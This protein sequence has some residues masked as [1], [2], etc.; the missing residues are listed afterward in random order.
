MRLIYLFALFIFTVPIMASKQG[1]QQYWKYNYEASVAMTG[2][3]DIDYSQ[4]SEIV[5]CKGTEVE[6]YRHDGTSYALKATITESCSSVALAVGPHLDDTSGET[7]IMIGDSANN[8]VYFYKKTAVDTFAKD[9]E[10][11]DETETKLGTQVALPTGGKF[12]AAVGEKFLVVYVFVDE[13]W[14]QAHRKSI[15]A[16]EVTM[17]IDI[18]HDDYLVIGVVNKYVEWFRLTFSTMKSVKKIT[19]SGSDNIG[20]NVATTVSCRGNQV[21]YLFN[22]AIVLWLQDLDTGT[23]ERTQT[24]QVGATDIEMSLCM[25][26]ATLPSG[27][28]LYMLEQLPSG[29]FGKNYVPT[30]LLFKNEESNFGKKIAFKLDDLAV[31]SDERINFFRNVDSTSC[32]QN[33]YMDISENRCIKCP[34]GEYNPHGN[35]NTICTPLTCGINEH[36]FEGKC[37]ACASGTTNLDGGDVTS[38]DSQ[39]DVEICAVDQYVNNQY[40]CANCPTGM[41]TSGNR[42]TSDVP[43]D[44]VCVAKICLKDQHVDNYECKT[45]ASG[46]T[47]A[48]GDDATQGDTQCLSGECDVDNYVK[49]N[50]CFL[51]PAGSTYPT[52][53]PMTSADTDCVVVTCGVDEKIEDHACVS[54]NDANAERA[55]GDLSTSGDTYCTCK[56]DFRADTAGNCVACGVGEEIIAGSLAKPGAGTVCFPVICPSSSYVESNVCHDCKANSF[57]VGTIEANGADTF[58]RC[59]AGYRSNGNHNCIECPA[60]YYKGAGDSTKDPTNCLCAEGYR[61]STGAGASCVQC[62]E[63]QVNARGDD[64]QGTVDTHCD[65]IIGY[66]ANGNGLCI[67]CDATTETTLAVTDSKSTTTKC[68]CAENHRV[69]V[70]NGVG[71]CVACFDGATRAAGDDPSLNLNSFCDYEGLVQK[72]QHGS[73]GFHL[74]GKTEILPDITVRVGETVSFVNID[75]NR[76][77]P[78]RIISKNDYDNGIELDDKPDGSREP[79]GPPDQSVT[80]AIC[81][82]LAQAEGQELAVIDFSTSVSGCRYKTG[83][84]PKDYA[85]NEYP[86]ADNTNECDSSN[87][88]VRYV[89][90]DFQDI[91]STQFTYDAL[92]PVGGLDESVLVLKPTEVGTFYYGSSASTNNNNY[93]TITVKMPACPDLSTH[94]TQTIDSS[95]T[96]KSGVELTGDLTIQASASGARR[97]RLRGGNKIQLSADHAHR[98]FTVKNGYTLTI[99]NLE[100]M[101]SVTDTGGAILVDGGNAVIKNSIMS[102]NKATAGSGGA[103]RVEN[104]GLV[105]ISDTEFKNNV[106]EGTVK[107]NSESSMESCTGSGGAIF[108]AKEATGKHIGLTV[109]TSTFEDN[110]AKG[111]GGG[112]IGLGGRGT[113]FTS[114]GNIFKKNKADNEG[115]EFGNG[116]AIF[117]GGSNTLYID[118]T[119]F[120][121]NTGQAGAGIGG[122]RPKNVE[123]KDS[124][125]YGN[126]AK[127]GGAYAQR[128]DSTDPPDAGNLVFTGNN[129]TGNSAT[130]EGDFIYRYDS[131]GSTVRGDFKAHMTNNA[132]SGGTRIYMRKTD[133]EVH[134]IDQPHFADGFNSSTGMAGMIQTTCQ[135]AACSYNPLASSCSADPDGFGV[136]CGCDMGVNTISSESS[137]SKT[138]MKTVISVLFASEDM[139]TDIIRMADDNNRYIPPKQGATMSTAKAAAESNVVLSAPLNQEGEAIGEKTV[140]LKPET[141][142]LC[143]SFQSF[144]CEKVTACNSA[145]GEISVEC[146]G[147][148]YFPST[149]TNVTRRRL[150]ESEPRHHLST[151]FAT[152]CIDS[153]PPSLT[154]QCTGMDGTQV[155]TYDICKPN[156]HYNANS[157][158]SCDTGYTSTNNGTVCVSLVQSCKQNYFVF[159]GLCQPCAEGTFNLAGDNPSAGVNTECD[160]NFCPQNFRVLNGECLPC[161]VGEHTPGGDDLSI[162]ETTCCASDEYEKQPPTKDAGGGADR[163]CKKCFG[164]NPDTD[165][166]DKYFSTL[167]CCGKGEDAT[168]RRVYDGFNKACANHA[169]S[170]C[171]TFEKYGTLGTGA[172]CTHNNQCDNGN[173]DI[174]NTD[175]CL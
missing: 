156:S 174:G 3:T 103:I 64:P 28:G 146:D 104:E 126:V 117:M 45:C 155:I 152:N 31:L 89:Q 91:T 8:K 175:K 164:N 94:G 52:K 72:F 92:P 167:K 14:K 50:E 73:G 51:C 18:N 114:V 133:G 90:K 68:L 35:N 19:G 30:K 77:N 86:F 65:C 166:V 144:L 147:V 116:G 106:A 128:G 111:S 159:D 119:F 38:V 153:S 123:L 157:V 99:E 120:E 140:L 169:S 136:A 49:N 75:G 42:Y 122:Y 88:C 63:G 82:S 32:R 17:H 69:Q 2:A 21:A 93:G 100:L 83:Y 7:F 26:T 139:A 130:E 46:S 44:T 62:G 12:A 129:F 11:T 48:A 124:S 53:T 10:F 162:S 142:V 37:Q 149:N 171:S 158:C 79:S 55:A 60:G 118:N 138:H 47:R 33:E 25:L 59:E 101:E 113:S 96:I 34:Q 173:C 40:Q 115:I 170:T 1:L 132:V 5:I 87:P 67:A 70:S 95:C 9:S 54:C 141:G 131:G 20:Y 80:K 98:F 151:S 74:E 102:N 23:W 76:D 97:H 85:F 148:K 168:C 6:Y 81:D 135:K 27:V 154:Q 36:V 137:L 71:E 172:D 165:D 61:A 41:T 78:L 160:D 84:G 58:C 145:T 127:N 22:N 125:F 143:T 24:L 39:C 43:D 13:N 110:E 112:A 57:F 107:C 66:R 29:S 161:A 108:L 105:T 121:E 109:S 150:M 134:L 56:A 4:S 16:T 163:I 15:S